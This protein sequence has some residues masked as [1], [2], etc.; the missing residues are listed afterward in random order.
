[1]FKSVYICIE[2]LS[3]AAFIG[4][5]AKMLYSVI[6]VCAKVSDCGK[7]LNKM[8]YFLLLKPGV[9]RI[10]IAVGHYVHLME[11][12]MATKFLTA[13]SAYIVRRIFK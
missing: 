5:C 2:Q 10:F 7:K 9:T 13:E 3:R 4:V 12:Y 1:M 11:F 6:R 8:I